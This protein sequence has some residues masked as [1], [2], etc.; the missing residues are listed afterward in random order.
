MRQAACWVLGTQVSRPP[1]PG[2][3]LQPLVLRGARGT[4]PK[5]TNEKS[6]S[7]SWSCEKKLQNVFPR[8]H[9]SVI[10]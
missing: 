6:D 5:D 2:S 1:T 3:A 10:K 8:T 9:F 7:F 4:G